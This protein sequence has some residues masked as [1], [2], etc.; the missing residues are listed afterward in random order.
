VELDCF[1]DGADIPSIGDVAARLET[2]GHGCLWS[3]EA[4]HDPFLPLV[5]AAGRTSRMRLGTSISVA[6]ARSPMT[7]AHTAHD[8][9][10][11]SSG[12][13]ILGLGPQVRAHIERRFSMPWS[14]PVARMREFVQALR[15]I[16]TAWGTGAPLRFEGE[17]YR[18]TLMAPNFDPGPIGYG[19]PPIY[20]AD[21]GPQM[22]AAAAEL[23]DGLLCHPLATPRYLT[24]VTIP[25]V[26]RARARRAESQAFCVTVSVLAATGPDDAAL[27]ASVANVRRKIAFY[28]ATPAYRPILDV[29]GLG[30][31]QPVL[32][33]LARQG[34]WDEMSKYI[35]DDV[36]GLFAVVGSPREIG[37]AVRQRFAGIAD[38]VAL[39]E[40]DD[41][42]RLRRD[43]RYL[44]EPGSLPEL[45]A[46]FSD[47]ETRI[48]TGRLT[49]P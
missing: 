9:H 32:N 11:L 5:I 27:A 13:F 47:R 49:P 1:A 16:W 3:V 40:L 35:G 12:R 8:L 10:R 48:P 46:G 43:G 18:H 4:Q 17:F 7:L 33:E 38:R 37:R 36:L 45:M 21:V 41:L 23:A 25:A 31:V 14:S 28:A 22:T 15:A 29:H 44:T 34:R 20:L 30:H 2:H 42:G 6:F 26:T 24:E 19:V 39:Y